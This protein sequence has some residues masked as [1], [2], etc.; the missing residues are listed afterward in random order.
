MSFSIVQV[1][2]NPGT[3]HKHRFFVHKLYN[4]SAK[5]IKSVPGLILLEI[6]GIVVSLPHAQN[7]EKVVTMLPL[8]SDCHVDC[9][10]RLLTSPSIGERYRDKLPR[11]P[12]CLGGRRRRSEM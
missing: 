4:F 1:N 6:W 7:R 12:R 10:R 11:A 9:G 2:G 3:G 8:I 5:H